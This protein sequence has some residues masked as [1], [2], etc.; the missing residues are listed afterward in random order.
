V[1]LGDEKAT[2]W[3][4]NYGNRALATNLSSKGATL[5]PTELSNAIIDLRE[6]YGVARQELRIVPMG[7]DHLVIPRRT[8]G[9]SAYFVGEN[10][11]V[12]E[13]EASFDDVSLLARKLAVLTRTSTE[14]AE[15]AVID[16]S[17]W[18]AEEIAYAFAEKEDDC[19]FNGDGTSTYGGIQ[20]VRSKLLG[21]AGAVDAASGHDTFAEID[22]TDLTTMMAALPQY[23]HANA[24]WYVSQT[25]YQLVFQAIAQAV[26][27]V[28]MLETGNVQLRSYSGY[29]IVISQ[30]MPTST[31]DLSDEVMLLFGDLS[32][33][34]TLGD[35]RSITVKVD[36]SRYLDYDQLAIQGTERFDIVVHDV[37]DAATAGP[38]VGLVGE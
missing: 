21:L 30:K 11:E 5:V 4:Q 10:S 6:Q 9:V 7:S 20:G 32:K 37:G 34:A 31:G 14:L 19:L 16:L 28:T 25:G 3:V 24:K 13:S 33:A 2:R 38:V 17:V 23:A 36:E 22:A 18:L 1:L 15:D 29:P 27:G 35:R 26:G 8:G 12:T